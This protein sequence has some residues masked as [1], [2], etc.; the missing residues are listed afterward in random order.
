MPYFMHIGPCVDG[1]KHGGKPI[2]PGFRTDLAGNQVLAD[3]D[4]RIGKTPR[5]GMPVHGVTGIGAVIG[6][7]VTHRQIAISLN[8]SI[9]GPAARLSMSHRTPTSHGRLRPSRD[10][11]K[12]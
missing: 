2:C 8:A 1:F 12:E 6:F 9:R 3:L 11:V 4:E 5:R 10:G 7:V